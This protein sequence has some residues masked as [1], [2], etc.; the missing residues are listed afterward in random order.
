MRTRNPESRNHAAP[1][2]IRAAVAPHPGPLPI[3][4]E[5][6][7]RGKG[8]GTGILRFADSAQND[9]KKERAKKDIL[10]FGPSPAPRR[11]DAASLCQ[12]EAR[13]RIRDCSPFGWRK[14]SCPEALENDTKMRGGK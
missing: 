2:D 4:G 14:R 6:I 1:S 12:R 9:R 8:K 5:G 13:K 11:L 10:E 3:Q 7:K